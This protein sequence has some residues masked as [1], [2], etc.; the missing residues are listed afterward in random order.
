MIDDFDSIIS[1]CDEVLI[2]DVVMDVDSL[3]ED[4]RHEYEKLKTFLE[5]FHSTTFDNVSSAYHAQLVSDDP[6]F[7]IAA[8]ERLIDEVLGKLSESGSHE[9]AW[10]VS[11]GNYNSTWCHTKHTSHGRTFFMTLEDMLL[12]VGLM[13][14][15]ERIVKHFYSKHKGVGSF[16]SLSLRTYRG[17]F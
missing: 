10:T 1:D 6:A 15:E 8:V 13:T 16:E 14:E 2:A 17:S 3:G 12:R 4:Y 9:D 5:E 7:R 11:R